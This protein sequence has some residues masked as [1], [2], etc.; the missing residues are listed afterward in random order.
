MKTCRPIACML[1]NTTVNVGCLCLILFLGGR[2]QSVSSPVAEFPFISGKYVI[3]LFQ[4]SKRIHSPDFHFRDFYISTELDSHRVDT[5]G[6]RDSVNLAFIK[7]GA[8]AV[9]GGSNPW[10]IF[11]CCIEGVYFYWQEGFLRYREFIQDYRRSLNNLNDY[12]SDSKKFTSFSIETPNYVYHLEIGSI[13]SSK[14]DCVSSRLGMIEGEIK[15][16]TVL[17]DIKS[18]V[19]LSVQDSILWSNFQTSEL[20]VDLPQ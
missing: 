9:A 15:N 1:R 10:Q 2:M 19:P 6:L 4:E 16:I 12:C 14:C 3:R 5:S 17:Y 11:G 7:R 8:Y 13:V 18:I 20:M